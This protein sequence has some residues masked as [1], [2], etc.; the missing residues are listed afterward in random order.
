MN[1]LK[2]MRGYLCGAMD[3]V[4]DGGIG[5]RDSLTPFLRGKGVIVLDPCNK[6]IDIGIEDAENRQLRRELKKAGA[7]AAVA[8]DMKIIRCVDLRMVDLSDFLVVNIDTSVHACGTYEEL[9]TANREKKP[10]IIRIEQGKENVPDWLLGTV[11]HQMIFS[12]WDEVKSYLHHIDT[13][14]EVD[15]MKRWM[16]F[17]YDVP[18]EAL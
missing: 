8:H 14:P 1:R 6:P 2:A 5:W 3:R 9:T 10:I 12:T 7:Y 15:A 16:F 13:A 18:P 11:P 17:N 4:P